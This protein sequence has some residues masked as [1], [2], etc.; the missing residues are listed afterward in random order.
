MDLLITISGIHN[1]TIEQQQ[2]IFGSCH[3]TV[4]RGIWQNSFY[5]SD[6]RRTT[7][8]QFF[9]CIIVRGHYNL[10]SRSCRRLLQ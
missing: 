10:R 6:I 2:A 3:E 8:E 7:F 5:K 4:Q 9:I 1:M